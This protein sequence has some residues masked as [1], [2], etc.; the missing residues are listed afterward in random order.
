T[1]LMKIKNNLN[2]LIDKNNVYYIGDL[3]ADIECAKNADIKSI[4]LLSGHGT[5]KGLEYSN[6]TYLLP[7]IK[8][9]LEIEHFK[10]FLKN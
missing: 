8:S 7:D 4:A 3:P 5:R 6:P 9:I 10:K 2:Y 1:A